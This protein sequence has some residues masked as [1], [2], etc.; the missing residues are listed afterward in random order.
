[1]RGKFFSF[2]NQK[3]LPSK[4]SSLAIWLDATDASTFT[5]STGADVSAWRNKGNRGAANAAQATGSL[6]PLY[7]ASGINGNPAVQFYD[8]STAKLLSI[9]DSTALDYTQ[10]NMFVVFRRQTDLAAAERIAGKFSV[11][12][13]ANQREHSFLIVATD[14]LQGNISADG[15]PGTGF[16]T[17]STVTTGNNYIGELQYSGTTGTVRVNNA[18]AG[19][20]T[21]ASIF[22][23]TSPFHIGARDGGADPFAGF[24]GELLFFTRAL[25]TYE[26]ALVLRYLSQKWEIG[27]AL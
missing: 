16:S 4:L 25:T 5:Y 13:P 17:T 21:I 8:D 3:F 23:G 1:M 15:L 7:V 14:E 12:T 10:M 2:F 24:I 26:R 18:N 20:A 19:T 27:V 22:N 11:T 6:Q 9:S